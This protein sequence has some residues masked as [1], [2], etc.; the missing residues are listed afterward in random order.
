MKFPLRQAM[1]HGCF[2]TLCSLLW[3]SVSFSKIK[4]VFKSLLWTRAMELFCL[5]CDHDV[6]VVTWIHTLDTLAKNG[7]YAHTCMSVWKTGDI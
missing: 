6:A 7:F 5:D 2:V 4:D 1:V 3:C